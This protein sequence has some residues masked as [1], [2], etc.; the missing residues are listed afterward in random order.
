MNYTSAG[1]SS[2]G[3]IAGGLFRTLAGI[4]IVHVPSKGPVLA[5]H[6]L[7]AGRVQILYDTAAL[8][9][10]LVRAG[11]LKALAATS[12]ERMSIAPDIPTMEEAGVPGYEVILWF[13]VFTTARTPKGIVEK[14]NRET[15]TLFDSPTVRQSL[16]NDGIEVTTGTPE[17][18]AGYVQSE[19]VK[20]GK[21]VHDSGARPE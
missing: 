12:R 1:I 5:L 19:I 6:E 20:W 7:V 17:I 11:K 16:A 18:L 3:H 9:M 15:V 10:S 13:A 4:D 8:S 2:S 14:L 21:M